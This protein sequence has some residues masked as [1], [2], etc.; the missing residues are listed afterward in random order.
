MEGSMNDA[1]VFFLTETCEEGRLFSVCSGCTT[2]EGW[3][4]FFLT[5]ARY[6]LGGRRVVLVRSF[7]G[8]ELMSVNHVA[9]FHSIGEEHA[10]RFNPELRSSFTG[11]LRT[12]AAIICFV[13]GLILGTVFKWL[14]YLTSENTE[15]THRI[16]KQH[17]ETIDVTVG[18]EGRL[19]SED[20]E[21]LLLTE[22]SEEYAPYNPRV[23]NL[24]IRG[25]GNVV[26]EKAANIFLDTNAKK[27]IL[28]GA[29]IVNTADASLLERA[30]LLWKH[31]HLATIGFARIDE[32]LAATR[33]FEVRKSAPGTSTF[34]KQHRVATLE[35]ALA[36]EP[37]LRDNGR[38]YHR[39]YVVG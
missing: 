37:P 36:D 21:R 11:F 3:G 6:L 18:E 33:K 23:Q 39:V 8:G 22:A 15:K 34:I 20:N 24:I 7:F 5:P 9:S 13:P 19:L 14:A 38:P 31:Q 12:I 26:L 1:G 27:I 4:N 16:I 25:D 29:Q 17:F 35:E 10:S 28:I 2:L 30:K 32:Q